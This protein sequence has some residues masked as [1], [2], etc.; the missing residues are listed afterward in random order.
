MILKKGEEAFQR[1]GSTSEGKLGAYDEG[2][3]IPCAK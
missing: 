3:I 2:S 1:F